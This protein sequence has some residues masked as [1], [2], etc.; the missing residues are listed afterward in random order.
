MAGQFFSASLW[1]E[2]AADAYKAL[3][4]RTQNSYRKAAWRDLSAS[5]AAMAT[6]AQGRVETTL[7]GAA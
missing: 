5:A 1:A 2:A 7:A 4:D 3:A 6:W